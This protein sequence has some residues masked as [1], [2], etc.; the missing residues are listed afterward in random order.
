METSRIH[1]KKTADKTETVRVANYGISTT[2]GVCWKGAPTH[3]RKEVQWHKL[4][5]QLLHLFG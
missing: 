4:W 5:A 2:H 3:R 1:V